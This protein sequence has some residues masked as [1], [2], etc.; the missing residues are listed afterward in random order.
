MS[1][2]T[3]I[4]PDTG[5]EFTVKGGAGLT[6]SQAFE[7]YN[8]QR[9][10]GALIN[11]KPGQILS[12]A[13]Q[14]AGGLRSAVSQVTQAA[15]GIAGS[16]AG[17]LGGAI[18]RV[19]QTA[20]GLISASTLSNG[21]TGALNTARSVAS[22][23]LSGITS[24]V[25]SLPVTNGINIANYAKQ[26]TALMP[27][28]GVARAL[29]E[30]PSLP[31]K[32]LTNNDITA[33]LA[34]AQRLV[35]QAPTV[36]SNVLGVGKY[37]LSCTQLELAG[38]V[39]PGTF[40]KYLASGTGNLTAVLNSPAVWTGKNGITDV[41]KLLSSTATQDRIQQTLMSTGLQSVAQLGIPVNQLNPQQL[42][43]TALNAAKSA[44]DTMKWASSG[45]IGGALTSQLK[46]QFDSVARDA[47]F[48]V[49]FANSKIDSAMSGE[50]IPSAVNFT[51]DRKTL[52]AAVTRIV[53]NK[54]IPSVSYEEPLAT[55]TAIGGDIQNSAD[56]LL[57]Q[58]QA[59]I[60]RFVG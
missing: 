25:S 58:A 35:G 32:G 27:I 42:A 52:N 2:F 28:K 59:Q 48:A 16:A 54:K 18:N 4:D 44:A 3:F 6:E 15:A 55:A 21:L 38:A 39:K 8:Q 10:V 24:A 49:D 45:E 30:I 40:N 26:A 46:S 1:Q 11:L 17:A 53:G 23:T 34:Q 7:I 5:R 14:V 51:V 56:E 20:T 60:N 33:T 29:D 47:A 37:G 57:A 13:S 12:A 31:L 43:G 22:K 41:T 36:V 9:D 19:T 50:I